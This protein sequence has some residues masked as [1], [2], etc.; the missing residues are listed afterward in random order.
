M[1][2]GVLQGASMLANQG[3]RL[4]KPLYFTWES[5]FWLKNTQFFVLTGLP[6]GISVLPGEGKKVLVHGKNFAKNLYDLV[7]YVFSRLPCC[8][9]R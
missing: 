6:D 3:K 9:F 2:T 5:Y 1:A 7:C 8:V 4:V